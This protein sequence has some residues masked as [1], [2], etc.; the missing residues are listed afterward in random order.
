MHPG[1][2]VPIIEVIVNGLRAGG[3]IVAVAAIIRLR[4]T[5]LAE[6][7]DG[8]VRKWDSDDAIAVLS[9]HSGRIRCFRILNDA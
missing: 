2:V 7:H 4:N 8:L 9:K 6:S 5:H 1:H 3:N